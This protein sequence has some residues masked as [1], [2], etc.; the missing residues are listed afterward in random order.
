MLEPV[1]VYKDRNETIPYSKIVVPSSMRSPVWKY[2]GFPADANNEIITKKKIVC[3]L[4]SAYIAYNKNTTNMTSHLSCKHPEFL[5]NSGKKI[6][7]EQIDETSISLKRS[8]V[9]EIPN[10][11]WCMGDESQTK[12]ILH[13]TGI[14]VKTHPKSPTDQSMQMVDDDYEL[15]ISPDE[16]DNQLI[17]TL[18]YN[19]KDYAES[20]ENNSVEDMAQKNDFLTEE[21][22]TDMHEITEQPL[23]DDKT[24][25]QSG[26]AMKTDTR[27]RDRDSQEAEQ[28]ETAENLDIMQPLKA[29]LIKDLV[30]ASTVDGDGFKLFI[31]SLSPNIHIPNASQVTKNQKGN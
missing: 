15:I 31:K 22:L 11:E 10:S 3:C 6:K 17:E 7:I 18:S 21:F 19:E 29:F 4:C 8:K 25:Q 1:L 16:Q 2:F 23:Y 30:S 27:N 12:H 13:P 5:G 9:I 26:H 28:P 20:A 14:V 24:S